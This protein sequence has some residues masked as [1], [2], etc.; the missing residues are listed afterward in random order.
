MKD[1]ILQLQ[2]TDSGYWQ[3]MIAL[4]EAERQVLKFMVGLHLKKS[5]CLS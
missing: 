5:L 2:K 4:V 1:R 3:I